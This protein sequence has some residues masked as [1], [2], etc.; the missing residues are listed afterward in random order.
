MKEI[1]PDHLLEGLAEDV[2]SM[3]IEVD[4]K[5]LLLKI[6]RETFCFTLF[7]GTFQVS[8]FELLRDTIFKFAVF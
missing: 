8:N 6:W 2:S 7:G 4:G 1:K 5:N 3:L